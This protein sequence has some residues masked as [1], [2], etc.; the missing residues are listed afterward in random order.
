MSDINLLPQELRPKRTDKKEKDSHS[1]REVDYIHPQPDN[2]AK[3]EKKVFR[4]VT[5]KIQKNEKLNDLSSNK[6]TK[7]ATPA[8]QQAPAPAKVTPSATSPAPK[9][10]A[11]E[12]KKKKKLFKRLEAF[13]N[14]A[15]GT[16]HNIM[17]EV[18]LLSEEIVGLPRLGPYVFKFVFYMSFTVFIVAGIW[19]Y[20]RFQIQQVG[21]IIVEEKRRLEI[22][23]ASVL[24]LQ[25]R[26]NAFQASF[27]EISTLY[28]LLQKR[29]NWVAFMNQF[30]SLTLNSVY[31]GSLEAEAVS[32]KLKVDLRAKSI[33]EALL[34]VALFEQDKEFIETVNV[35]G[36]RLKE[37]DIINEIVLD[38]GEVIEEVTKSSFI[39]MPIE[40]Q[41]SGSWQEHLNF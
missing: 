28:E 8:Q 16:S 17:N 37:E 23:N 24:E 15:A 10:I 38:D 33:D 12:K 36:F 27:D 35:N 14:K 40:I 31:Y 9:I 34:Q 32:G 30:E 6:K 20:Y 19:A 4:K 18:E 26:N 11:K 29:F 13:L 25:E 2:E 21:G 3:E 1:N 5:Q 39:E 7:I 41:L 22:V